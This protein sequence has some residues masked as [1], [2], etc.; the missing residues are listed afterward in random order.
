[1]RFRSLP[2]AL[3]FPLLF[4][5]GIGAFKLIL[6]QTTVY[7]LAPDEAHYWEWS[8]RLDYHYYSKGPAIAWLIAAGT[9]IFGHTP[10]GVRFPGWLLSIFIFLLLFRF[11][12]KNNSSESALCGLLILQSML[13]YF[14]LG[15]VMTAD[16]PLMFC[17]V[18]AL[19]AGVKAL[20]QDKHWCWALSGIA[21]GLA[22]LCKHS[23]VVLFP[24]MMVFLFLTPTARRHLTTVGFLVGV[25]FFVLSL[26]PAFAWNIQHHWVSFR[27]DAS[28]IFS[29]KAKAF[30]LKHFFS[31]IGGQMGLVG[32]G[33]L[34]FML[35]GFAKGWTE[36]RKGDAISGLL[37]FSSVPLI[38]VCLVV[39]LFKQVYP[40]WTMPGFLGAVM[41]FVHLSSCGTIRPN[42][43]LRSA[44]T[45]NVMLILLVIPFLFGLTFGVPA[46]R[47]TMKKLV[48]WHQ[49]AEETDKRI[50]DLKAKEGGEI[51]VLAN[52]YEVTSELAF[53]MKDHP[54][55][56][57]VPDKLRRMNQYDIWNDWSGQTGKNALI[58]LK[59]EEPGEEL[60]KMFEEVSALGN[61]FEVVYSGEVVRR[62]YFFFGKGLLKMPRLEFERY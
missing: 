9:S 7:D 58:I 30:E 20:R 6:F 62:F 2:F 26:G 34:L 43:W 50:W 12:E 32:P 47:L 25:I 52:E 53:Y 37:L 15:L 49:L 38:A 16:V 14:M 46:N 61:P 3:Y 10:L 54:K 55:V 22:V 56:L 57:C 4:I 40:N 60:T 1:M 41:L 24:A 8:R 31:F 45:L 51:V 5:L 35:L 17:W 19:M 42:A 13:F 29:A 18:V 27:H 48:G 11:W 59:R 33:V 39:S 28:H 36:W 23:G 21:S 44:L